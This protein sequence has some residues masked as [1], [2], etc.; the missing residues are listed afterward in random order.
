MT[1]NYKSEKRKDYV[2]LVGEGIED[3]LDENKQIHQM[4]ISLCKDHKCDRVLIDDQKV[5]YTAS[6]L[7][8]YQLAQY[9]TTADMPHYIKRAAIV[10]NLKYKETNDFFENTTRNRGINLRVF[11]DVAEAEAWLIT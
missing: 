5:T 2:Y 1:I 3:G 6:V 9:Y 11:Y 4:I 7:S 8:I 10:A